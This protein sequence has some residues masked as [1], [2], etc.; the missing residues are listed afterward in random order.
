MRVVLADV[1]GFCVGVRRAVRKAEAAAAGGRAASLGQLIHNPQEVERL[2]ERGVRTV[3]SLEEVAGGQVVIR[4]HGAPPAVYEEASR[5]GLHVVDATC[6]FVLSLQRKARA[7]ADEGYHV[8]VVG[9]PSHPEV[10]GV[11]GWIGERG[12][13]VSSPEEVDRLPPLERVGVVA[14]TT[15]RQE[16]VDAVVARLREKAREVRVEN[17]ICH[18]TWERQEAARR[19]AGQVDVMVVV[20]GRGSSN[21]QK[22]VAVCRDAGARTYHI[23]TAGELRPEWL[24][25][26]G[27]VGVTAGASTP[28]WIVK[29]VVARMEELVGTEQA[30]RDEVEA[31]RAA[32]SGDA[33]SPE[34]GSLA[35]A[36]AVGD[37]VSVSDAGDGAPVAQAGDG[38]GAGG[39]DEG[40]AASEV[41][42]TAAEARLELERAVEAEVPRLRPGQVVE[43]TV[44]QVA[45]DHL[46]VDV[47]Q[48]SEGVVPAGEMTLWPGQSPADVFFP[49]QSLRVVV[50]G[51]DDNEGQIRLSHRRYRER[52]AWR[53]LEAAHR[54]GAEVEGPV[55]E[56]VKGGLVVDL[57]LRAFMPA[58]QVDNGHVP[59]LSVYLGQTLR[60]RVIE[61][62]RAN[63]RVILSRRQILESDLR[64]RREAL[65]AELEPGQVR[66]GVVKSVTD[67][68]AFVDLGGL[69]GLVH[70]SE[71]SWRRVRHPSEVVRPGDEVEV[72]VLG[73]DREAGRISLGMKQT[74]PDPWEGVEERYQVGETFDG[75]VVR[76]VPFGAFVELEPGVEGLVHV[77]ELADRRVSD[78]AEVVQEGDQVRVRVLKVSEGDRRI[79]LSM[80]PPRAGERGRSGEARSG[81]GRR[82]GRRVAA[83]GDGGRLTVGDVMGDVLTEA[84]ERLNGQRQ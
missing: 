38:A 81:A 13:V 72:K 20:G 37:A 40:A 28:E 61:L 67:F 9:D 58:S 5:R 26:A 30:E 54:A 21:A 12:L 60:A 22:L 66:R 73:L 36:A 64:Q 2:A 24:R 32:A 52:E 16:K 78:P 69:D 27:A 48:K 19:L 25:G 56:V 45:P 33:G 1:Y 31:A 76:L 82:P 11:V 62:D 83:S 4:A 51:V 79:S 35:P 3:A 41:D 71:L 29:E 47:G 18:A 10:V 14:Q 50:L 34:A 23:E 6:P 80:R 84:K 75:R 59:D 57:G 65:W 7:L 44:V 15:Q 43:G 53:R 42:R 17:T 39:A 63:R 46:L 77:S 8:V 74:R 68:G 49:G 70:V 55:R